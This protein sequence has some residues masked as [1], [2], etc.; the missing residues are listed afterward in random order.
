MVYIALAARHK[1]WRSCV[2]K[3]DPQF[4]I[5]SFAKQRKLACCMIVAGRRHVCCSLKVEEPL[6]PVGIG[7]KQAIDIILDATVC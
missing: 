1:I 7:I 4:D 2:D 6:D 3:A 5:V